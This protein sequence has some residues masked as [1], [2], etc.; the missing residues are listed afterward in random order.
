METL[1]RDFLWGGLGDEF[2]LHLVRWRNVREPLHNRGLGFR[3][4]VLFNQAFLG[5]WLWRYAL[6]RKVLWRRAI[7]NKYGSM[8][9]RGGWCLNRVQGP[10]RVCLWKSI[11]KGWDS[12]HRNISFKVGDDSSSKFWH[13]PWCN[14][15]PLKEIFPETHGIA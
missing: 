4:L 8:W 6:G 1:Q 11:R 12:F 2:K 9:G 14:G 7:D 10:Y 5:K 13:D 3:N 15:P